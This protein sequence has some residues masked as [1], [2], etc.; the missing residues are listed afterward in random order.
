MLTPE[1][2]PFSFCYKTNISNAASDSSCSNKDY[3]TGL[4]KKPITHRCALVKCTIKVEKKVNLISQKGFYTTWFFPNEVRKSNRAPSNS[5]N[6][7]L[8]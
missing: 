3:V 5:K 6:S 1:A 7:R 2:S 8:C 4:G